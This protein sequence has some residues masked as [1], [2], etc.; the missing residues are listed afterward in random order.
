M[1]SAVQPLFE[2]SHF[3]TEDQLR[4]HFRDYAGPAAAAFP[5]VCLPGLTRNSRDFESLAE[6][7]AV[8]HRVLCPDFRGRGLS[9]Y[10]PDPMTYVP[11]SY[12]RDL[13]VLLSE[14][15]C[16]PVVLIG[17]SLGGLVGTLF[18]AV[19]PH[20]VLGLILN[21]VGPEIDPKGLAR[22]AGYVG[23][24]QPI[25][26]WQDAARAVEHLD[27]IVYPDYEPQ[28]WMRTARRRYVE[29]ADGKV[30]LDYDLSVAKTLSSPAA[31]PDQWPFLRRLRR[32]PMLLI[33]GSHSDILA[34]ETPRRMKQTVPGLK[35]IEVPNRGHT[36]TLDEPTAL[37]A[38]DTFLAGLSI[39]LSPTRRAGLALS[40]WMF[41]SRA[42]RL[43]VI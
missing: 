41:Q 7:L 43:G 22:I 39:H 1:T 37:S 14:L 40:S 42:R 11:R 27:R 5:V 20:K 33:R 35:V 31:T 3:R 8:R 32:M 6:H 23:K 16:G 19:Y 26:T 2:S 21:D 38:I 12:V 36:P 4:L 18:A 34:P 29:G 13:A 17:T 9:E 10:A 24:T 30:R 28:D 25:T 15:H